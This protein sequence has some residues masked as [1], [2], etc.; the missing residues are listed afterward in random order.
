MSGSKD[1]LNFRTLQIE[2]TPYS[3]DTYGREAGRAHLQHCVTQRRN[4]EKKWTQLEERRNDFRL[5]RLGQVAT[6]EI[7]NPFR[8][9]IRISSLRYPRLN[10]QG[11]TILAFYSFRLLGDLFGHSSWKWIDE[12]FL[13]RAFWRIKSRFHFWSLVYCW[14]K[15]QISFAIEPNHREQR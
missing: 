5:N 13:S 9:R 12:S 15:C 2:R 6:C 10:H 14:E 7:A 4:E 3:I 1:E 11:Q 8:I